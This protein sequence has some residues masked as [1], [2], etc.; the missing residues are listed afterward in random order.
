TLSLS[1]PRLSLSSSPSPCVR[2]L[3]SNIPVFESVITTLSIIAVTDAA[4]D[5]YW[6]LDHGDLDGV[7]G[8]YEMQDNSL[9]TVDRGVSRIT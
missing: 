8:T 9:D 2:Y 1:L 6:V 4:A 7:C 5:S 3:L